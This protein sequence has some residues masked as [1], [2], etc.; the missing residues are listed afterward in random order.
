[1]AC[2]KKFFLGILLT[3]VIILAGSCAFADVTLYRGTRTLGSVMSVEEG[4]NTLVPIEDTG[5]ILG[6]S[7]S[8]SSEELLLRRG[9][10]NLRVV[11][12]SAAAWR[13]F[14][15]IPLYSAPVERD[16][17][18][19]LDTQSVAALFQSSVGLART[20][21][22]RFAKSSGYVSTR[23]TAR[24]ASEL[25]FGNIDEEEQQQPAKIPEPIKLPEPVKIPEPVIAQR[26]QTPIQIS[27]PVSN[28][29]PTPTPAPTP[30]KTQTQS[31]PVAKSSAKSQPRMQTFTPDDAKPT[32]SASYSGNLQSVR[33][34]SVNSG[35]HKRI[36]AVVDTD[37][38]SDPQVELVNA[39]E[40]QLFFAASSGHV[41]GVPSPYENVKS[42]LKPSSTGTILAFTTSRYIKIEKMTLSSPRRIVLD[43]YFAPEVAILNS[44]NTTSVARTPQPSIIP[45]TPP[46]PQLTIPD[47]NPKAKTQQKPDPVININLP[48]TT[49]TKPAYTG[50]PPSEITIP[51]T[52]T[53]TSNQPRRNRNGR[54]TVVIDPGH[55]GKDPGTSANGVTE[56]NINL[57][58]GLLLERELKSRGLN[59]IMTRRTDVYLKL[60]ERTDIANNTDAD[61]FVSVHV[62][63]LPARKTTSGFEIYIMALPTDK[64]ALNLAKIENR[65]YVEGKGVDVANVD[66]RTEMLLRILGDMQQN[67]KI[68]ESTDFAAALFQAGK[69]ENLPMK[70]VAQAP[71]FVIRGAGMPAVLLETGFCTNPNEAKLLLDTSYQQRIA[72]AMANGIMNYLN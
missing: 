23:V 41:D 57:S 51:L 36:R 35:S 38:N 50:T 14:A 15:I 59:V 4:A 42:E 66:R 12:N 54:R 16:G 53:A 17:K 20:D 67:N 11:L 65:E 1:M 55:G 8:R 72:R 39:N 27:N 63:A 19:W 29:A 70:R 33:W 48:Q 13:G 24:S 5:S 30:V 68:S 44:T 6:F 2:Y 47:S 18:F 52:P 56:K 46:A 40:L 26:T 28:P 43:F 21:R 25:D 32:K 71:F 22:L 62:N 7:F 58:I 69:R 3:C 10:E 34:S 31:Q 61:L 9:S 37:E 49:R 64:D 60:Q 45:P